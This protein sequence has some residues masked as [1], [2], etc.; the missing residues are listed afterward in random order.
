MLPKFLHCSQARKAN[1]LILLVLTKKSQCSAC[2]QMLAKTI[3]HP[4][5]W[6]PRM[7]KFY[8]GTE[9][10]PLN[11]ICWKYLI[12]YTNTTSRVENTIKEYI[13]LL[14]QHPREGAAWDRKKVWVEWWWQGLET[15]I[16]FLKDK[17]SSLQ[18]SDHVWR[19]R[20]FFV[21]PIIIHFAEEHLHCFFFYLEGQWAFSVTN[22]D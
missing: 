17:I 5:N 11:Y 21:A 1:F 19:K 14:P 12:S 13:V 18:V 20:P 2:S 4:F 16:L 10:M 3:R 6:K 22:A 8:Q 15:Q 7:V 9:K